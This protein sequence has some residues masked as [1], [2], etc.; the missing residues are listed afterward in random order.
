LGGRPSTRCL[1]DRRGPQPAY[2]PELTIVR[3]AMT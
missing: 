2:S 1:P 3:L